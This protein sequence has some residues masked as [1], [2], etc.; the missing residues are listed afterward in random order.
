MF[1]KKYLLF[2]LA[3]AP[4][5]LLFAPDTAS[6]SVQSGTQTHEACSQVTRFQY[7]INDDELDWGTQVNCTPLF[8]L[9][10]E[11]DAYLDYEQPDK[12]WL[13]VSSVHK[14]CYV[15][16]QCTETDT[17]RILP[18]GD[19]KITYCFEAESL[20]SEWAYRCNATFYSIP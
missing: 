6:A 17:L 9:Y 4:A 8:M 2:L 12:T 14:R 11:M 3:L 13:R 16:N 1:K 19:Y 15:T 7:S 5:F 20:T 18:W 10:I